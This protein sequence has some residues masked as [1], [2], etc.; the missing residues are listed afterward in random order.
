MNLVQMPIS[1]LRFMIS[2]KATLAG[3]RVVFQEESYTSTASFIDGDYIPTYDVDDQ[4]A[5]FS[6]KRIHRGLYQ[7]ASGLIVNADINGAANI[8][9]KADPYA[10]EGRACLSVF[11]DYSFL[12]NPEV[13]G[14]HELNP[15]SIPVRRVKAA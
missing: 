6:G 9:R 15:K 10:W 14:F 7:T 3:I 4:S 11:S 1:A 8:L 5:H 13:F 2:Y 12:T